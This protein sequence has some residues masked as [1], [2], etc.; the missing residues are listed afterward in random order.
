[1]INVDQTCLWVYCIYIEEKT[2]TDSLLLPTCIE[3][4]EELFI[5]LK[6]KYKVMS[7]FINLQYTN[8]LEIAEAKL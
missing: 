5:Q 2:T 1:M 3:T 4:V 6:T 8:S 7:Y